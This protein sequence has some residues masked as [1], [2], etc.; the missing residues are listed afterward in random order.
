MNAGSVVART[1]AREEKADERADPDGD[2]DGLIRM[3]AHS[4]VRRPDAFDRLLA[5][6]AIEFLAT[7]ER[8]GEA[9]AG[10]PDFFS[11]HVG[12]GGHQRPR[13]FGQPAE[14]LADCLCFFVHAFWVSGSF[15]FFSGKFSASAKW[16]APGE[17]ATFKTEFLP[18][19][20]LATDSLASGSGIQCPSTT[21][22]YS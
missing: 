15:A 4:F 21:R 11:G 2:A 3:L 14:V 18:P 13:V 9:L 19:N 6:P 17:L 8:H 7:F 22:Q 12:R 10:I 5:D 1:L 20:G 16:A